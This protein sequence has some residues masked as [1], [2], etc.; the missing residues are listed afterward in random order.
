MEVFI[1]YICAVCKNSSMMLKRIFSY[2]MLF[3]M[4][5]LLVSWT[6]TDNRQYPPEAFGI[7]IGKIW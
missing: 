7:C 5:L 6:I 4:A 3:I 2:V 1:V